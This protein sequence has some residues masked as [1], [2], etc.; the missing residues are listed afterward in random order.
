MRKLIFILLVAV[1]CSWA[2]APRKP[3]PVM[4]EKAVIA[5][6]PFSQ[7]AHRWQMI[8]NHVMIGTKRVSDDVLKKLDS[9]L[10]SRLSSSRHTIVGPKLL[11][12][13]MELIP[14]GTD[15]GAAFHYWVQVARCVPADFILV[16]FVF[17]WREREG[18]EWGVSEPAMVVFELNLIDLSELRLDRYLFDEKQQALTENL[19]GLGRF[20]QRGAKWISARELAREGIDNGVQELGL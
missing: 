9:D 10:A 3:A 13:C 15:P 19:L 8:N 18:G 20:L 5:V 16:P 2:C 1:L 7:P 6:A 14:H 17:D 4:P 11:E 12:Q